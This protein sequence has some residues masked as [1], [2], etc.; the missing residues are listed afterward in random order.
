MSESSDAGDPGSSAAPRRSLWAAWPR[1]APPP[2]IFAFMPISY[3]VFSGYVL[4]A[5][6]WLL[7]HMGYGVSAIGAIVALVVSPMTLYF[8]VSP[9]LDFGLR[10]RTWMLVVCGLGGALLAAAIL[11]LAY[12]VELAKWLLF[13]GYLCTVLSSACGGALIA[14]T[15]DEPGANRAAA[16]MQGGMLTAAAFGGAVLLYFSKHVSAPVLAAAGALMVVVPAAVA[17]TIPEPPPKSDLKNL[18]KTCSAMGREIRSTLFSWKSLPGLL[19]LVSPIGSG[20]GQSLFAAMAKDY[21]VGMRG[22]LLL[23][24]MLGAVLNMLGAYVAVIVP[25]HWDRRIAYAAAGLVC[26]GAGLYLTFAPLTPLSYYAGVAAYMLT[27]GVCYGFF[28]GV[29]MV[30]MG[31]AGLSA[32]SRY[33]ILVSLGDLPIVYMTVV[34]ARSY[35]LFGVRG[36]PAADAAGNLVV[37]ACAAVWIAF[38]FRRAGAKGPPAEAALGDTGDGFAELPAA[39]EPAALE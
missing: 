4:T 36:V 38:G 33:A 30:T 34:E 24:G 28:L 3:A 37:A 15:Q 2:W 9:L 19:L 35:G 13:A 11:L 27:T 23:N 26:S 18:W 20:A 10:R 25:A 29:V 22:V 31:E 1:Q 6:P 8:P 12:D 21:H 14:V 5:L 16:W 39:M 32:G 17:L 7:R